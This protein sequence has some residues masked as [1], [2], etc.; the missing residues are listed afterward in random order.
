MKLWLRGLPQP[1]YFQ[2]SLGTNSQESLN[3]KVE[4]GDLGLFEFYDSKDWLVRVKWHEPECRWLVI[5]LVKGLGGA[6]TIVLF[7]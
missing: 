1:V 7:V 5:L 3:S 2:V 4:E 6:A